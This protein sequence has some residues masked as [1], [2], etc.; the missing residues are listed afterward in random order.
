MKLQIRI[1]EVALSRG[2]KTA[3]QLQRRANLAPSTASRLY[4]NNVTQMTVE[5]LAKLCDALDCDAAALFV[6]PKPNK[7]NA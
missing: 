4:R 3:Y 5:T 1:R 2:V 6:R 7:K